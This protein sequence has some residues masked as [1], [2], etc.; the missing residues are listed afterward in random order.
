MRVLGRR[1]LS[2]QTPL[3]AEQSYDFI[4]PIYDPALELRQPIERPP[5]LR[6]MEWG[7]GD[8]RK[9]AWL[10]GEN[11]DS[12][13]H[14]PESVDGLHIIGERTWFIR[15]DWEWPREER[16]LGLV[17]GHSDSAQKRECLESSCELTFE[18]YL[19]GYGQDDGQLIVLN[20]ERQLVGP[21]Y[22]WAAVNSAFARRLGWQPSNDEPFAWVD[23]LGKLMVKSV[24][25]RDGW[26]LLK[27]PRFESLGEG[28]FVLS[29]KEGIR[30][31]R[32]ALNNLELH[33]WVERH[34]HGEKPY[35][36]KWHLSRSI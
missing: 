25:W 14:Y 5:E 3:G 24:Y 20:S 30:S 4:Y 17:I 1:S 33:L 22:R 26:I 10:R 31:I 21:A 35:D 7:L 6:A 19:S 36:G 11:A 23:S 15:P 2:G 16:H 8:D 32:E 28:W 18:S 27:P 34:S 12:W 29:T 9:E 13:S